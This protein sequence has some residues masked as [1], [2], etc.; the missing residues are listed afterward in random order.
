MRR[1]FLASAVAVASLMLAPARAEAGEG[2][3][4]SLSWLRMPGADACIATQA[5]ARAVEERLGRRVFVSAAQADVSV[6]GHIE[7]K[8]PAGWHAVLTIRD[9]QGALLGTR[10]LDRPEASCEAMNEPLALVIAVMIDPEAAQRPAAP[11][12]PPPPPAPEAPPAPPPPSI[13]EGGGE[14]KPREPWRFEGQGVFTL[15]GGLA[16]VVAPGL[17][18][19][20]I[21]VPPGFP[22]GLRGYGS[23]F[24][25]TNTTRDG[26]AASFDLLY[27]G[28]AIC[29]FIR[30]DLGTAMICIGGQLGVI[31][32]DPTTPSRG[33]DDKTLPLWNGVTELRVS[34]PIL[35][36]VSLTAGVGGVLPIVRPTFRY[37]ASNG[38]RENLHKVSVFGFTAAV[39]AGFFFP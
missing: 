28:S 21:I 17:G 39:G 6:E 19:D 33:I 37:T 36:P 26:A 8:S 5:L 38:Q 18:V 13:P 1:A 20:A 15:A 4:S 34:V 29:P 10:D 32:S 23:I 30:G 11:P 2:R 12:P 27:V 25:P 24:L 22:V 14:P 16:P 35:A 31:R 7:K 9:G 3:T